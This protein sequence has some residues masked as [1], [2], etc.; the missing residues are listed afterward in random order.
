[1]ASPDLLL[2]SSQSTGSPPEQ[3][4]ENSQVSDTSEIHGMTLKYSDDEVTD[5]EMRELNLQTAA[6][7]YMMH[8]D[9]QNKTTPLPFQK[10]PKSQQIPVSADDCYLPDGQKT[11]LIQ[12]AQEQPA[13]LPDGSP[14]Y[15]LQIL[16]LQESFDTNWYLV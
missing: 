12:V 16:Y 13:Q 10:S 2:G 6:Q 7:K 14:G 9:A 4:N 8:Q 11:Q 3:I 1:M 5:E 15:R